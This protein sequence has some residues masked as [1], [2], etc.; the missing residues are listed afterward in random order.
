MKSST[1]EAVIVLLGVLLTGCPAKYDYRNIVADISFSGT[2]SI[3]VAV[4]DQRAYVKSGN[5][6]PDYVGSL[7]GSCLGP[8]SNATLSARPL[9][10]DMAAVIT[11]SLA[12]KGYRTVLVNVSYSDSAVE[13]LDAMKATRTDRMILLT[14]NE[15][16]SYLGLQPHNISLFD[17]RLLYDVQLEIYDHV[18]TIRAEKKVAG[19]DNLG[20]DFWSPE[21]YAK[22]AAPEAFKKK[23][24]EL[25]NSP[26]IAKALQ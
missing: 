17:V 18:G 1:V 2:A 23:L 8:F 21:A 9:A 6:K 25:L 22:R 15:W 24:E 3:S 14:V 12:K 4:Y 5:K 16:I 19:I 20:G 11:I 10:D 13:V 26:D 7:G